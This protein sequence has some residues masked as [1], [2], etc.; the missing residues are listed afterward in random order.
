MYS[1]AP[2]SGDLTRNQ[3]RLEL[4][5]MGRVWSVDALFD[6]GAMSKYN[7][8]TTVTE[9]PLTEGVL[10]TGSDDGLIHFSGDSGRNWTRSRALPGVPN[11]SFINDMEASLHDADTV[12]A[13]ADAHKIGDFSPYV[14]ESSDRGS[15]WRSISGDLPAGGEAKALGEPRFFEVKPVPTASDVTDFTVV[16]AFQKETL[17]LMRLIASAER[18]ISR[19]EEQLQRMRAA[20]LQAIPAGP[21]LDQQLDKFA[22]VLNGLKSRLSGDAIR[23][24]RDEATIPSIKDRVQR[25]VSYHWGTRQMPTATQKRNIQIASGQLVQ[26]R[27]DLSNLLEESL[28]ALEAELEAAG[29]PSWK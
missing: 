6:H 1:W 16:A 12:F 26:L 20:V 7:T 25:V 14:F 18:D 10:Y 5:I 29:A 17:D 4:D 23:G 19:T 9:S 15:S 3:N 22:T 24:G 2:V 21:A 27:A 28:A 13:V 8:L 11:G